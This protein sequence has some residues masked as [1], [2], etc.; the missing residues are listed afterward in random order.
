MGFTF[1]GNVI[2]EIFILVP[3]SKPSKSTTSSFGTF[4]APHFNSTFLLTMFST[5]PLFKPGDFSLLIN[6][7]GISII[8]F[9]PFTILKKSMCIGSSVNIS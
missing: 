6:F 7:T 1:S 9:A 8:I 3:I 5:P 4:S 2:E